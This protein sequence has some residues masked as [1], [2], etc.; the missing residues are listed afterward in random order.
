LIALERIGE[1][2]LLQQ[3]FGSV[4]RPQA[5]ADELR[6]G[7]E[8]YG[9]SQDLDQ[10]PWIRT[11]PDPTEMVL[12]RELGAGETAAITLP[13]IS[14]A[15]LVVLD[16]LQARLVAG[17][18]GLTVTGTLGILLAARQKGLLEDLPE[19]LK[20]LQGAGFRVS[21]EVLRSIT[22]ATQP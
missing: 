10:A 19:A 6:A 3:L 18:P 5:V 8:R 15:D 17:G 1:L 21:S 16:D 11:E 9:L 7:M 14:G 20:R 2:R 12:R 22:D 4:V 13:H